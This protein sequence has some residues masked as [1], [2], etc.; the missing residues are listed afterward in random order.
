MRCL[1]LLLPS[2]GKA[3]AELHST[4]MSGPKHACQA[5]FQSPSV[6]FRA[7]QSGPI[8]PLALQNTKL[9]LQLPVRNA[10][11]AL[12]QTSAGSNVKIFT[13]TSALLKTQLQNIASTM[14]RLR[15]IDDKTC[16][17]AKRSRTLMEHASNQTAIITNFHS[18]PLPAIKTRQNSR[19]SW[20]KEI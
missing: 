6:A 17:K 5:S 8:R 15:G 9:E 16:R 18:S 11:K 20:S 19:G 1:H 14:P 10:K 7:G 3:S 4:L 13:R 2:S 12:V